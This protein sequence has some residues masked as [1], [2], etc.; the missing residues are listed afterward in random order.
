MGNIEG[1]LW[2]LQALAKMG[3]REFCLCP[4]SR[5]APLVELLSRSQGL[6]V[7]TFFEERSAGFFALG[8]AQVRGGPVAVVTTSGTAAA[9]LLPA[10]IEAHYLGVP[11]LWVT[12]DRPKSYRL[13]GAPQSIEQV[14]L[15]SAYVQSCLDISFADGEEV[16]K[17]EIRKL[18]LWDQKGPAQLNLCFD[19]PLVNAPIPESQVLDFSPDQEAAFGGRPRGLKSLDLPS[20]NFVEQFARQSRQPLVIVGGLPLWARS[21]VAELLSALGAPCI[22]EAPSGLRQ[23]PQSLAGLRWLSDDFVLREAIRSQEVDGILRLGGVPS[24][25]LWRDLEYELRDLPVLSLAWPPFS[26]LSEGRAKTLDLESILAEPS[27]ILKFLTPWSISAIERLRE[28]DQRRRQQMDSMLAT[29][30]LSE[31]AWVRHF[32]GVIGDHSQVFLGNSLPIREWDLWAVQEEKNWRIHANRGANGIDGLVSTFLGLVRGGEEQNWALLG[33][34]SALYDLAGL[35]PLAQVE[36]EWG[37]PV[38]LVVVNNGGGQIFRS[39][40]QNP[41]YQNSHQLDFSHWAK[42]W[43]LGYRRVQKPEDLKPLDSGSMIFEVC[44]DN[45]ATQRLEQ[46]LKRGL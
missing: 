44:P 5:N 11:L 30:P 12:A 1:S 43:G 37:V 25:R 32:S 34:L 13:Q 45:Q 17:N 33:D 19:E 35:W 10:C 7:W 2:L 9:E 14:G 38:Q 28:R 42:M 16:C 31:W 20:V 18:S 21:P 40:Y 6:K 27:Q 23:G 15:F 26:G 36:K 8:R 41:I 3:V 46:A 29:E 39:L 22:T 4:G 24:L